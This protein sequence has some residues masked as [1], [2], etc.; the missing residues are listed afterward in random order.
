M[1]LIKHDIFKMYNEFSKKC[2]RLVLHRD[3]VVY[4]QTW[5]GTYLFYTSNYKACF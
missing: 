5:K 1:L 2:N 4:K 3:L